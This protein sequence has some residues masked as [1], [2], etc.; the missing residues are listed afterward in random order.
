MSKFTQLL[1]GLL[2][3]LP[4]LV[5]SGV[6]IF[7]VSAQIATAVP[8]G[9]ISTQDM[10]DF[11][12]YPSGVSER[13]ATIVPPLIM[14]VMSRDEQLF[15][16]AYPDYTALVAGGP[17]NTT[18]LDSFSYN[19][20]FDPDICYTYDSANKYYKA[21]AN[22]TAGTHQC[23]TGNKY[24]SGNFMNWVAM[25]RLDIL[26]WTFYG[27]TRSVD[28]ATKTVLERAEIPDDIHAWPKIY[29]GTDIN[30]FTPYST[31]MTF[32]NV[33]SGTTGNWNGATTTASGVGSTPVI[34][35]AAGAWQD[36]ASTEGLQCQLG[37]NS[38]RPNA[39]DI[40]TYT[41]RVQVCQNATG[42]PNEA[43][44]VTEGAALKPEG[45]LQKYSKDD[46]NA[47]RFGLVT[48]SAVQARIGGQLRRNVGKLANNVT[49]TACAAGTSA[50]DGDEF[51]S[52][53]GTFCYKSASPKP[54]EGIVMTLDR[55]QI[56]GWN[57]TN[58]GKTGDGCYLD[59]SHPW[60]A[61]GYVIQ[62]TPTMCPDFG[63]PLAGMYATALNYIQGAT[64]PNKDSSGPLPNPAWVD[65]YGE[66]T[67]GKPRNE[68]CASC[69]VVLVSSGLNTF[70]AQNVPTVN[71]LAPATLTN[72]IQT[73][74]GISGSYSLSTYYGGPIGTP[75]PAYG[76]LTQAG[77]IYSDVTACK[78][79]TI[80]NL[81]AVVGLC[82]GAPG[83]QGGYLLA[84]LA[85]GAWTTP[86]RTAGVV[87][88][89][90]IKT[91]GVSLSD[92]LPAFNIPVGDK[93][94]S[95]SPSC[96]ANPAG[97]GNYTTCYIGNVVLNAQTDLTKTTTYGLVP[98]AD[99]P[100]VGSYYIMWED[101]QYG[102]DHDMDAD[103]VISW[104]VGA[105]CKI[106][107]KTA[108]RDKICD[109]EIFKGGVSSSLVEADSNNPVCKNGV[110]TFTPGDTDVI[111]RNEVTS[112]S[113][114]G[115]YL[116]YQVSGSN[117]DGLTEFSINQNDNAVFG[118]SLLANSSDCKSH[119]QVRRFTLGTTAAVS[120]LQTPLW[121][122]AKYSG[123]AGSA[124]S[125]L[126]GQDPPNYFFARNA[127]ALK[128]QLD[129]V[130]Q[131]ITSSAA[132]NFGNA[133]TPS[134][135]ND[136][137]G[138]G[139]AYQVQYFQ[140]RLGVKWSGSLQ[141]FWSDDNGFRR[142][143]TVDSSGNQVLDDSAEYVVSGKDTTVGALPGATATYRC[144]IAPIPTG[145]ATSFEPSDH[146]ECV[147]ESVSN[148]LKPA[149]D[150]GTLLNA[151]Y[152]PTTTTGA[153][154]IGN[155]A[156]QR[157]YGADA[158][159]SANTGERYIFTYLTS[160]PNTSTG[161]GTVV[162]GTQTDF[163]WRAASC[164]ATTGA[165]TLSAT[166]GFC[167]AYDATKKIRT[168]NY[169]LLNEKN[170][171]LA[172]ELVNWVR[173]VEYPA[174]YRSR[175]NNLNTG[176]STY[177]LG[178]IV[179]SSPMI[180]GKPSESYDLLYSDHSYSSFLSNYRNRRQMVYVGANDG[181]LH[182]FNGGFYV[183]G[184]GAS[185][186][187]AATNPTAY[188]TLP[189]GLV[190]GNA[191]VPSGNDWTLGQEVWAFVPD[192]LLPHL[193]W[194]AQKDY[195]H[196]FY[197]DGSPVVTDAKIFTTTTITGSSDTCKSGKPATAD[198]DAKGHVCGWGTV[199]VVPFRLGGGPI[200]VD[201]VGS[202]TAADF[203][204]SNSAYVLLDV[205]DPE[206]PPTV[207]GEITTGS[208]TTS[209][210]AFSVHKESDGKL[211]YLLT[212]GS[213]PADN[214]GPTGTKIVAA[215]AGSKLGVWVY[216]L[217]TIYNDK[218]S[219]PAVSLTTTGPDNSFAGDM[220]SSDFDL[221]NSAEG[222]YF[223]VVTNP[224]KTVPTD[225]Q[226]FLGGLW[227]LNMNTGTTDLDTSNPS[228][229]T[230]K[231][232]I[233]SGQPVTA[234][235]T[236][237][238]DTAGRPMVYFG[239]GRSFTADDDSGK[240]AQGTQQQYIYGVSDNSLLT[241]M[242]AACQ[243]MPT[244]S[245]LFNASAVAVGS[246]GALSGLPTTGFDDVATLANLQGML[247]ATAATTPY[248][249]VYSG[250]KMALEAGSVAGD[251]DA[252]IA[253][254]TP[255]ERVVS[256]QTLLSGVLLTPTYLPPSKATIDASGTSDCNPV[257]VP[258]SSNLYGMNYLTGT[259]DP[260]LFGSFGG[261]STAVNK[262]VSLGSGKASA[263]VLHS[264]NGKVMAAFGLSGGTKL[265][266]IGELGAAKNGEISWREPLEN[267]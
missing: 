154:A 220:I 71:P 30:S 37:G 189:T 224:V 96:R 63:N 138:N 165:Y 247:T 205:T 231:Q 184:Q 38:A 222:V 79:A 148:P 125:L 90:K 166:S 151:Y 99:H 65:P 193:R 142:E 169:G 229:F 101:S 167:G 241:G 201:T 150:A 182:A 88:D 174:D 56:A 6:A 188:R 160:I 202:N 119:P 10:A 131:E 126:P 200:S 94:I 242:D 163:V 264:A 237:A 46:S 45:L 100:N 143:G 75:A 164:N 135:S 181:M 70:D 97:T 121:Y 186:T 68:E 64:A 213:G 54:A 198:I 103:N 226:L 123:Y 194:L 78:P 253:A 161:S 158:G 128:D 145:G 8:T 24:W 115:M 172:Q 232:V 117:A 266:N 17:V 249:F 28:T 190:S 129:T 149:W 245:K 26:R 133:T 15:N 171:V 255:S 139:L 87:S 251:S 218:S 82:N 244:I 238:L 170:P 22:V 34:L 59:G 260:V 49:G 14:L 147:I 210:P 216:D 77:T 207:L 86:I 187:T 159:A 177:R 33:S 132:N 197:V 195:T 259:A 254:Q 183:T 9:K 178:D 124:P 206:Q 72:Q 112:F 74:E 212:I 236:L 20:Y 40:T 3:S 5:I 162:N 219:T 217:Q 267:Q 239:S 73:A 39:S 47:K 175:T 153:T 173:G 209:S 41:A 80:G 51:S 258:G 211:H 31:S 208:F 44:C 179:D 105:S 137:K 29:T 12:S 11:E 53:D 204:T 223:G 98:D 95:L 248:C 60:G 127:G 48:G 240:S 146:S 81:S 102:S 2:I 185:G 7:G 52:V 214:G 32:C 140:A 27:G 4:I 265:Q 13:S 43:F 155:G 134:S 114:G 256:S 1:R 67:D 55:L 21:A 122:A 83:Q 228:T 108:G 107:S 25:S 118:C 192:N 76:T 42:I 104:C 235:P 93:S 196:V 252:G 130:F 50:G 243:A 66:L 225:P 262:K 113:S 91:Y 62:A 176:K 35:A 156:K 227:K 141:A 61:R 109:P 120:T 157:G 18:Y 36:W 199:M 152:D 250:W 85:Y 144:T 16:K 233:N 89:F 246:D 257:P 136:I 23:A 215:A 84:G 58:Y 111:I 168:G 110:L 203:Q 116:G 106:P 230:L 261:S 19:G 263:P 180:V 57:G 191:T 221:D 69:S 92:N 234:R